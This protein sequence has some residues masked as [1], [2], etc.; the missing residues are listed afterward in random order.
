[1]VRIVGRQLEPAGSPLFMQ[2]GTEEE[3]ME[4]KTAR[5]KK[6]TRNYV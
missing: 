1:M 6:I 4:D 2:M 3:S 5:G